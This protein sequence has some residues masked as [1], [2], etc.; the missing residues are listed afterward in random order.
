[1]PP[2]TAHRAARWRSRSQAATTTLAKM[3]GLPTQM[4]YFKPRCPRA[5]R[6]SGREAA[7]DLHI[8]WSSGF[9]GSRR[10]QPEIRHA[11]TRQRIGGNFLCGPRKG[12]CVRC[13]YRSKE[14]AEVV[15]RRAFLND[16]G[17]A[18][19]GDIIV[20]SFRVRKIALIYQSIR[21]Q[22][23]EHKEGKQCWHTC[24]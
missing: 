10:R 17:M 14:F 4:A 11:G 1:M 3:P 8:P 6:P 7:P 22:L 12:T 19:G 21:R 5:P 18:W 23:V 13:C 16:Q 20:E 15:R 2:A 9:C 24:R